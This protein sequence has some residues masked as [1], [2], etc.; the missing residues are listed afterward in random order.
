MFCNYDEVLTHAY[1]AL[2]K[3]NARAEF[4]QKDILV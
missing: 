4:A 1:L 2:R 3:L